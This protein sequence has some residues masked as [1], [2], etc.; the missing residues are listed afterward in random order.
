MRMA[1]GWISDDYMDTAFCECCRQKRLHVSACAVVFR[2][3]GW[4]LSSIGAGSKKKS[5]QL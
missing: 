2:L 1:Y 5:R 3:K 4:R